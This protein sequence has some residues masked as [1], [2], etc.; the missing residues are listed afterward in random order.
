MRLVR[1]A[2]CLLTFEFFRGHFRVMRLVRRASYPQENTVYVLSITRNI[3]TLPTGLVTC[4]VLAP[5]KSYTNHQCS[6]PDFTHVLM[7][8]ILTKLLVKCAFITH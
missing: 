7:V 3:V 4:A 5:E 2:P 8:A 1:G 6:S